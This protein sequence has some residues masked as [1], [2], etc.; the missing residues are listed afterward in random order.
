M[1]YH[2]FN[3]EFRHGLIWWRLAEMYVRMSIGFIWAF[4]IFWLLTRLLAPEIQYWRFV[5][6]AAL[7]FWGIDLATQ[8]REFDD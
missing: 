1:G 5:A 7:L 6:F 2:D 3:W 8:E 4:I